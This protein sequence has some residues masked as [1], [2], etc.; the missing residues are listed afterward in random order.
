MA[1]IDRF[2]KD[3][4]QKATMGSINPTAASIYGK[5]F[6][7]D[8]NNLS[9]YLKDAVDTGKDYKEVI[10]ATNNDLDLFCE[11]HIRKYND[12][13]LNVEFWADRVEMTSKL[14]GFINDCYKRLGPCITGEGEVTKEDYERVEQR[15]FSRMWD[16]VCVTISNN[17]NDVLVMVLGLYNP[18]QSMSEKPSAHK[19]AK[20]KKA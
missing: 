15:N 7:I 10:V 4:T 20:V 17:D 9:K 8:V 2:K 5:Y 11:A 6:S 13:R 14:V 19:P 3:I 18:P 16:D 12:G 1:Q